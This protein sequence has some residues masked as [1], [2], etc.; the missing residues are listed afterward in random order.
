MSLP[1]VLMKDKSRIHF[2]P[3]W[4]EIPAGEDDTLRKV[5]LDIRASSEE[6]WRLM[7]VLHE[8]LVA[9]IEILGG[10]R[11]SGAFRGSAL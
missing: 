2:S 11:C 5:R 4:S 10:K 1:D 9:R 6:T 8:D 7:R 3:W